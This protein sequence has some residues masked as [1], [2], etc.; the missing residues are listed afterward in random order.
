[1][2]KAASPAAGRGQFILKL[3]FL[4]L[5]LLFLDSGWLAI[6]F[7]AGW[8]WHR[9]APLL[10]MNAFFAFD[11][12]VRKRSRE[13]DRYNRLVLSAAFLAFPLV[14]ALPAAE[15]MVCDRLGIVG[16]YFVVFWIG[17][18]LQL[19]GGALLAAGRLRLGKWGTTSIALERGHVLVTD[20]VYRLCRNPIYLGM[21]VLVS[22]F[23]L[24]LTTFASAVAAGAVIT[25]ICLS[26]IRME[27]KMLLERFGN[28]Y[29]DYC[30]KTSRLMPF[31]RWR[32]SA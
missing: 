3:V 6:G 13:K 25:L 7:S 27:E 5:V 10:L 30:R 24:A 29:R 8:P 15:R 1:M 23:A 9:F 11:I 19:S 21:I 2:R 12:I 14:I 26:R 18:G 4:P 28:A 31:I 17:L 22:G 16:F 32:R 20:G